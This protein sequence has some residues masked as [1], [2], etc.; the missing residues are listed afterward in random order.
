MSITA[1]LDLITCAQAP[2]QWCCK[3]SDGSFS[4][5]LRKLPWSSTTEDTDDS[6][7]FDCWDRYF[8]A[9][10][11]QGKNTASLELA[12]ASLRKVSCSKKLLGAPG[13]TTRSNVGY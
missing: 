5:I 1:V 8:P 11:N 6:E 10:N 2:K 4:S 3:E 13:H 12:M 7:D 9:T